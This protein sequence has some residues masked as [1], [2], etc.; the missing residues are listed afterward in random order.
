MKQRKTF[1]SVFAALL[2]AI[3]CQESP[4]PQSPTTTDVTLSYKAFGSDD[5]GGTGPFDLC[6]LTGPSE[7]LVLAR[8]QGPLRRHD[9][10]G[11]CTSPPTLATDGTLADLT[12]LRQPDGGVVPGELEVVWFY[13]VDTDEELELTP[14]GRTIVASLRPAGDRWVLGNY[15]LVEIVDDVPSGANKPE[16]EVDLPS[17]W[18]E[19]VSEASMVR[20]DFQSDCQR[21]EMGADDNK[22]M[23]DSEFDTWVHTPNEADAPECARSNSPP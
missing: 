14:E 8:V 7:T 17:T 4:T 16:G 3:S 20:A 15:A 21:G 5:S 12:I 2:T 22:V 1:Y 19:L 13:W 23:T 11:D 6:D 18:D 9:N 10:W